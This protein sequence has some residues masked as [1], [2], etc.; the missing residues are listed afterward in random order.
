MRSDASRPWYVPVLERARALMPAPRTDGVIVRCGAR[1][2]RVRLA[3]GRFW[4]PARCRA[5]GARVDPTRARRLARWVADA[6]RPGAVSGR[7]RQTWIATTAYLA[8]AVAS[9]ACVW[10]L[11]DRWWPATVLLFGPRWVLLLPI[12]VLLPAVLRWDRPLLLPLAL[13][14]TVV[15][16][17]VLGLQTGWRRL[18]VSPDAARDLRVMSFNV[19]GGTGLRLPLQ[20]ML[21]EWRVDIA[22]FQECGGTLAMEVAAL[23]GWHS[24]VKGTMCL[25][26]RFPIL[27]SAEMDRSAF[28]AAGGSGIVETD[29][30]D[31]GGRVVHVT[32]VHLETPRAGF[33]EILS[34]NFAAGAPKLREKSQLRE[35]EQRRARN[36][37]GQYPAPRL[38]VGDFNSPPESPIF[39]EAWSGWQNAFS[40]VGWGL[41]GTRLNGWIRAR[42][43]HI[44]LD[45]AWT[46][47]RA[48]VGPDMGSDHAP[49][50]AEVR[51]R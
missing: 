4:A 28:R 15:L 22:A 23:Q 45:S 20:E 29:A 9:A 33:E 43:D 1:A 3:R 50:L 30:L 35:V 7:R 26:S 17:P 12:A 24:D 51:L 13:A 44:L 32:N 39:R 41:G 25:V 19:D 11:A 31:L 36:W 27:Q 48:R 47:V 49:I 38:V 6:F 37:A 40:R 46:V 42:I 21:R 8:L 16:G 34:G 5:C 14:T 18:L 10:L 2:H